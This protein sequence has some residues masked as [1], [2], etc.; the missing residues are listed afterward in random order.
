VVVPPIPPLSDHTGA[1]AAAITPNRVI[2]PRGAGAAGNLR[3]ELK[4]LQRSDH[5][6]LSHPQSPN[7]FHLNDYASPTVSFDIPKVGTQ[8]PAAPAPIPTKP[9][10]PR[11]GRR[12]T[13][14]TFISLLIVLMLFSIAGLFFFEFQS[15]VMASANINFGPQVHPISQV[16]HIKGSTGQLRVDANTATIPVKTL[17][18]SKTGS[19]AGDTSQQCILP[20]FGCQN[21]VTSDDVDRIAGELKQSLDNQVSQNVKSQ[22]QALGADQVGTIVFTTTSATS[23]PPIGTESKTVTVTMTEEGQVAYFLNH[24]AQELAQLLLNQQVQKLGPNYIL[25]SSYT[26]VGQPVVDGVDNSGL[27]SIKIA[28]GGVTQYQFP[29]AQLSGI[30]NAIRG[31]KIKDAISYIKQQ[32][33]V[34]ANTV[35]IHVTVGTTMPGD[36]QHMRIITIKPA[37]YPPVQLPG[38]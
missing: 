1:P 11:K 37:N 34:D 6:S 24:D 18:G 2:T 36:I 5:V 15:A 16:F 10:R 21:T 17:A 32:P 3:Q 22:L 4:T 12:N 20:G 14:F 38:V 31:K 23:D 26:Q 7:G 9:A 27:V 30:K 29:P 35:A 25:L 33:G 8:E 28:A 13:L 19:L